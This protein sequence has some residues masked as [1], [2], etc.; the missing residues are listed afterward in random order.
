MRFFPDLHSLRFKQMR[1][2]GEFT[3][4]ILVTV[5]LSAAHQRLTMRAADSLKINASGQNRAELTTW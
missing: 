5:G 3:P 4:K 1:F 2:N